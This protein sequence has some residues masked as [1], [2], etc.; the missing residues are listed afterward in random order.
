MGKKPCYNALKDRRERHS[1]G[2]KRVRGRREPPDAEGDQ[3]R[4]VRGV[5]R[6][7][8]KLGAGGSLTCPAPSARLFYTDKRLFRL[9][10]DDLYCSGVFLS[11]R[12]HA[13]GDCLCKEPRG[14]F[15]VGA[16]DENFAAVDEMEGI[17]HKRKNFRVFYPKAPVGQRIKACRSR[18]DRSSS[19]VC[20]QRTVSW[21]LTTFV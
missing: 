13:S 9:C 18:V 5:L 1:E 19:G 15:F 10:N 14:F 12:R 7:K 16:A 20:R 17:A 6:I 3:L 4:G 2:K 8:Q 21:S 11:D